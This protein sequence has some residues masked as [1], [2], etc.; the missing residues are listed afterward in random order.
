MAAPRGFP[1]IEAD[2]EFA[3]LIAEKIDE[4][5]ERAAH[6]YAVLYVDPASEVDASDGFV[7]EARN[8][9]VTFVR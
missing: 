5:L 8:A 1:G 2:R 7:R 6:L 4:L 3:G 9:W